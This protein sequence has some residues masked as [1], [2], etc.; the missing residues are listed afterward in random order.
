M[1]KQDL[2]VTGEK[3]K[4]EESIAKAKILRWQHVGGVEG[5][6]GIRMVLSQVRWG[7]GLR[8]VGDEAGELRVYGLGPFLWVSREPSDT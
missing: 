8:V 3:E 5:Q 6:I 4:L 2:Q 7:K 1:Q